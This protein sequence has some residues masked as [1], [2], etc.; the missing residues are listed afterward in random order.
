MKILIAADKFKGSLT[1]R[2]ACV[3]I[4]KGVIS[5]I[6]KA[7]ITLLPVADGGEGTVDLFVSSGAKT[8]Y[9]YV[10]DPL[11]RKTRAKYAILPDDTTIIEM[12]QASGLQLLT[13][14]EY[15]PLLTDTYG[16]GELLRH[17]IKKG[18]RKIILGIG[19]SGT[20][21]GGMGMLRALGY[22]FLDKNEKELFKPFDL[23][24]LQ[25][26]NERI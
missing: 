9:K 8:G 3:S 23:I 19:G 7:K 24:H 17:V 1:S 4:Q 11:G 10:N 2:Q 13:Q 12:A 5:V 15:N 6:P 22:R 16:T 14:N 26:I 25:K 18:S 21:D 20:N